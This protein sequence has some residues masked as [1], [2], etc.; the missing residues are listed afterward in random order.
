MP[1]GTER[2]P[3]LSMGQTRMVALQL[4]KPAQHIQLR[5]LLLLRSSGGNPK[6]TSEIHFRGCHTR[7]PYLLFRCTLLDRAVHPLGASR[8]AV[9]LPRSIA[10]H[11]RGREVSLLE[12]VT[13]FRRREAPRLCRTPCGRSKF[14]QISPYHRYHGRRPSNSMQC[15]AK[16]RP[17]PRMDHHMH[18]TPVN[19]CSRPPG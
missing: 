4:I 8:T 12:A 11:P 5:C 18:S 15:N 13:R 9:S 7:R 3:V 17:H 14:Q 10:S 6:A 1:N 2:Q 16:C 19:G